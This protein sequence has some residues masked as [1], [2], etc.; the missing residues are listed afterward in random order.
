MLPRVSFITV[1]PNQTGGNKPGIW[2][3][4]RSDSQYQHET[5]AGNM[6]QQYN[7]NS[8]IVRKSVNFSVSI[9]TDINLMIGQWRIRHILVLVESAQL[10]YDILITF[11][12]FTK[13]GKCCQNNEIVWSVICDRVSAQ[14]HFSFLSQFW[15]ENA[16]NWQIFFAW[17]DNLDNAWS[18]ILLFGLFLWLWDAALGRFIVN[19]TIKQSG[20]IQGWTFMSG[21]TYSRTLSTLPSTRRTVIILRRHF[22]LHLINNKLD[23]RIWELFKDV[24]QLMIPSACG[25]TLEA[26]LG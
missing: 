14:R 21:H 22:P 13:C 18:S 25:N 15:V 3:F 6:R 23:S 8:Q 16:Q 1:E 11:F 5:R 10:I 24:P 26:Y 2:L 7:F 9:L 17:L 12:C 4:W 19:L 20:L